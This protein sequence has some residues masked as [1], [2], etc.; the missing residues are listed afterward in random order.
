MEFGAGGAAAAGGF[1][2]RR[3]EFIEQIEGAREG[4]NEAALAEVIGRISEAAD[5]D[6][7]ARSDGGESEQLVI[8]GAHAWASLLSY[9]TTRFYFEGPESVFKGGFDERVVSTL[10][11]AAGKL[12]VWLIKAVRATGASS[13]S[14]GLGYPFGVSV[15]LDWTV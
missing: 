7:A 15:A 8:D 14:I 11:E 3:E 12:K 9:A 2:E 5:L 1:D 13:F 4:W 10:Q 6:L